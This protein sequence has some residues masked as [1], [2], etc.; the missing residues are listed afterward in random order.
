MKRNDK[1]QNRRVRKARTVTVYGK[2]GEGKSAVLARIVAEYLEAPHR[3]GDK[4][5]YGEG[6]FACAPIA[7]ISEAMKTDE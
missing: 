5:T 2:P 3:A 1:K 7:A 4:L 6:Y